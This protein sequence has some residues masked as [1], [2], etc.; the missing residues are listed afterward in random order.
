MIENIED[1][2]RYHTIVVMRTREVSLATKFPH[3]IFSKK[4]DIS[5][6]AEK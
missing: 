1:E 5:Y 3:T 6:T 4:D 2:A